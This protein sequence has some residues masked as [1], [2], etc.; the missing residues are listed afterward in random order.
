M[1]TISRT[2]VALVLP[3]TLLWACGDSGDTGDGGTGA[4]GTGATGTAANGTGG[5][6]VMGGEN[7]G[8][9]GGTTNTGG[10][11]S[12][13]G[14]LASDLCGGDCVCDNGLDDDEDGLI[15]GL[16]PE[17]TGPFDNDEGTFATGI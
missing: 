14:T 8:T 4:N 2:C 17:C 6:L 16:D 9:T 10:T 15:D 3:L 1:K 13:G 12:S 7:S 5:S 11:T